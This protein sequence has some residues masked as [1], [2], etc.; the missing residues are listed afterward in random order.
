LRPKAGK[1][2][3]PM[4]NRVRHLDDSQNERRVVL[5]E[6]VA[7]TAILSIVILVLFMVFTYKP[8]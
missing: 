7:A 8:Y 2:G 5:L 3:F 1:E 4:P 6:V